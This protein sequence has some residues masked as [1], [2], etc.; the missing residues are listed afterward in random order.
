MALP[1]TPSYM[2]LQICMR[3][4]GD[5]WHLKVYTTKI[6]YFPYLGHVL[7]I[8][9]KEFIG[10]SSIFLVKGRLT[11]VYR[12]IASANPKPRII[13]TDTV[14][15]VTL[16]FW[17]WRLALYTAVAWALAWWSPGP[18]H[19]RHLEDLM[20]LLISFIC[21]F[22]KVT[23]N[24][25]NQTAFKQVRAQ[26]QHEESEFIQIQLDQGYRLCRGVAC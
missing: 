24:Y 19:L 15:N 23:E 25:F 18:H 16:T 26:L 2:S 7:W 14:Y 22:F 3:V 17:F 20:E 13:Q 1:P 12:R 11:P 9:L 6:I 10:K 5:T 21:T 8:P 4:E